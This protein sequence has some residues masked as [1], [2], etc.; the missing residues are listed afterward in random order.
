MKGHA[1]AFARAARSFASVDD[2]GAVADA[3]ELRIV[4]AFTCGAEMLTSRCI[5]TSPA[6]A[7]SQDLR[8]EAP[9]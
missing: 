1:R 3:D 9:G 2:I 7:G 8:E 5:T 4:R 6:S